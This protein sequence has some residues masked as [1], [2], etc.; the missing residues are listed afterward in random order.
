MNLLI[1]ND[2]G[3]E[4][5]GINVLAKELAKN[6]NVYVLAPLT[7]RSAV[8][9]CLS[10][11]NSLE[12]KKVSDNVWSCSGFPADC[13]SIAV[14]SSL[15]KDVKFDGVISGINKGPNLGTD[16]IFSGTC[17]AARQACMYR[18]PGVALS[19]DSNCKNYLDDSTFNYELLAD[20]VSKNLEKI[21]EISKKTDFK[22]F[23]NINAPSVEKY[24]GVKYCSSLCIRDYND[25]IE[26]TEKEKDFYTTKF[27]FGMGKTLWNCE[28]PS[29]VDYN[30]NKEGCV[31]ISTVVVEPI[32]SSNPEI[33]DCNSF[34]L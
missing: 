28:C 10:V 13:V 22:S 19:L 31:S 8:S 12:V 9:N 21:L 30:A 14:Q 25:S 3:Y 5:L 34:S 27:I 18:I 17:A 26:I 24:N 11:H 2:D 7:N 15:F 1:T 32:C 29:E 16:I 23:V 33:V 6:H 4:A 20:F